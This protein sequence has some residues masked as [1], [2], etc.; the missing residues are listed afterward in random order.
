M[1]FAGSGVPVPY[2]PSAG[3]PN[4]R[5]KTVPAWMVSQVMEQRQRRRLRAPTQP[6]LVSGLDTPELG[7]QTLGGSS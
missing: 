7:A 2:A 5:K 4:A 6:S 1:C 3:P